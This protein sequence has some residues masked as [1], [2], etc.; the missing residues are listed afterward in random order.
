MKNNIDLKKIQL[1]VYD[2]DG[3]MTDNKAL[4]FEDGSEAVIVNR[5]DGLG[6]KILSELGYI[7]IILSTEKNKVV[8]ARANKL[9]IDSFQGVADKAS[10][11]FEICKEKNIA[12]ENV[13]FVGNDINDFDVMKMVGFPICPSD[14]QKMIKNISTLI[15]NSKGGNGVIREL[16]DIIISK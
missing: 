5:G 9:K 8:S 14:A 15:L 10:V 2:F 6:V 3:V 4:V 13:I 16:A 7:Q 12:L 11:L 1:I